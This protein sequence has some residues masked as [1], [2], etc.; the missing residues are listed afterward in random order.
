MIN[1][2]ITIDDATTWTRAWTVEIRLKLTEDRLYEYA[3]HE[4][5]Y[6]IMRGLVGAARAEQRR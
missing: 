2:E 1:Y 4:G 5:N 3:C 6:E